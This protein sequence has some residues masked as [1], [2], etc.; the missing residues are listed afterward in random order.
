[1][2]MVANCLID[3]CDAWHRTS[4]PSLRSIQ[5]SGKIRWK[6]VGR[7]SMTPAFLKKDRKTA[8]GGFGSN[9][10]GQRM[11]D[12]IQH[13]HHGYRIFGNGLSQTPGLASAP[14]LDIPISGG[15]CL[16]FDCINR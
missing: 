10:P 14:V 5:P 11:A 12:S 16:L 13:H 1:M 2:S 8:V 6:R 3:E 7:V 15:G 4:P 9:F